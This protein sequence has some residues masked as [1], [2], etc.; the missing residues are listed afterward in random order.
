MRR[1]TIMRSGIVICIAIVALG[2]SQ[3]AEAEQSLVIAP[4]AYLALT[5]SA[6]DVHATT[7]MAAARREI[8]GSCQAGARKKGS[9]LHG[10]VGE[11]MRKSS[12]VACEYPPRSHVNV[13]GLSS[14][15]AAA[16]LA[17]G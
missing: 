10:T 1:G 14:V 8:L 9:P 4:T 3:L 12:V 11:A 2:C 7:N 6:P 5:K 15:A 17:N 13:A 16:S